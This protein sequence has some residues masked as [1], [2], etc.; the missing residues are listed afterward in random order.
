MAIALR[1]VLDP[2]LW[3]QRWPMFP[4]EKNWWPGRSAR[5]VAKITAITILKSQVDAAGV[6]ERQLGFSL[7]FPCFPTIIDMSWCKL[8]GQ[9]LVNAWSIYELA[10]Q[11]SC[12]KFLQVS[13][14]VS[15]MHGV[16]R[17]QDVPRCTKMMMYQVYF[18]KF[19]GFKFS[20]FR[21]TFAQL[22]ARFPM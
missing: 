8:L 12:H 15:R 18:S 7:V 21:K 5:L 11:P 14:L 19:S 17:Y 9:C 22:L 2:A 10:S 6:L 13:N 20:W 16:A 3:P 1:A 4:A